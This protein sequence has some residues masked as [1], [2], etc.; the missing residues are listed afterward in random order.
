MTLSFH[1]HLPS[2][3]PCLWSVGPGVG[4][5]EIWLR[6]SWIGNAFSLYLVGYMCVWSPVTS[7]HGQVPA[8]HPRAGTSYKNSATRL[9]QRW[10]WP[11]APGFRSL[12]VVVEKSGLK[13][14][15]PKASLW[16]I[17]PVMRGVKFQVQDSMPFHFRAEIRNAFNDALYMQINT[18]CFVYGNWVT[19]SLSESLCLW[20][21]NL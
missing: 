10:I 2:V 20:G 18:L 3:V 9:N 12:W 14:P 6:G 4:I 8:G 13:C 21:V 11:R 1:Y 16:K 5:W 19:W 17:L 15:E 7:G